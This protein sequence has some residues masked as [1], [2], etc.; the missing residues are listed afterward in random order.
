MG[1]G[2]ADWELLEPLSSGA[3]GIVYR[4]CRKGYPEYQSAIKVINIPPDKEETEE[5]RQT[6]M[7]DEQIQNLYQRRTDRTV[8]GI[9]RMEHFKGMS[10]LVSIED[11]RVEPAEDG[12][13]SRVY[14]RMEYLKPLPAYLADKRMAEEETIQMG[15]DLCKALE[16]LHGSGVIH[17]DIKPDNIF[18]NDRLP[19]GQVFKLGDLDM[20]R[21]LSDSAGREEIRGTPS[22]MAPEIPA[23]Q[24]P[25]V[26]TDL[27]ELGLT[28]YQIANENRLPF[29]PKRQFSSHHDLEIATQMRFSGTEFPAPEGVSIAFFSILQKA[30]AF[31]P[32]QRYAS[33]AEM[34]MAL[35]ALAEEA[36]SPGITEKESDP[37]RSIRSN[38]KLQKAGWKKHVL[39]AVFM[40]LIAGIILSGIQGNWHV[41]D[42][43]AE[44]RTS[45]PEN[46]T[47]PISMEPLASRIHAVY[48]QVQAK[49]VLPDERGCC[50]PLN[51]DVIPALAELDEYLKLQCRKEPAEEIHLDK[52]PIEGKTAY[53]WKN[54]TE[55]QSLEVS[56]SSEAG[57]MTAW[58]LVLLLEDRA[59]GWNVDRDSDGGKWHL[60]WN[61]PLR[62]TI[63]AEYSADGKLI[64]VIRGNRSFETREALPEITGVEFL[65]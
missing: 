57:E 47:D 52:I 26:R 34:R 1:E 42:H 6:G 37:G 64:R 8:T 2:W 21:E 36:K 41:K 35:E 59:N 53:S 38:K 7:T 58:E 25:D 5:L 45:V 48:R 9:Q 61:P 40:L 22:Y 17:Q 4:A 33:A 62:A 24:T 44:G 13:G 29:L 60:R 49:R 16:I 15:I 20:M 28:L 43:E 65:Q 27:Y 32:E 51:L 39:T 54:D 10:N 18:V 55:R 63:V 50:I 12:Y 46:G 30:C 11:F 19:Y 56:Y 31:Q 23:G 14:V 3:S